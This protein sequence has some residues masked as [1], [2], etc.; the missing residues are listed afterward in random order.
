MRRVL[1]IEDDAADAE[2]VA[3]AVTRHADTLRLEHA[4]S[5]PA[6]WA[7]LCERSLQGREKLPACILLDMV[8]GEHD[9]VW[10]LTRMQRLASVRDLPVLVLSQRADAVVRARE[11]PNVVGAVEKPAMDHERRQLVEAVLRLAGGMGVSA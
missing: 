3:E 9:G 5:G 10:F 7:L 11:F 4:P 1:L 6:A 2:L 8:L